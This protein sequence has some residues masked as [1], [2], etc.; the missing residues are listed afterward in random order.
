MKKVVRLT[1]TDLVK[2]VKKVI[3]EQNTQYGSFGYNP[4]NLLS[5][6]KMSAVQNKPST[7]NAEALVEDDMIMKFPVKG[8]SDID[9]TIVMT[10]FDSSKNKDL[11]VSD[12]NG[13]IYDAKTGKKI[14]T[15]SNFRNVGMKNWNQIANRYNIET[16][17][18]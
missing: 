4:Y 17:M 1:E 7:F 9:G 11:V 18:T 15:D 13:P 5:N 2:L 6:K 3:E 10:I 14:Y 16:M 12:F 8:F